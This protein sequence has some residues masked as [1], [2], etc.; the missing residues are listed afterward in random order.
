MKPKVS[1]RPATMDDCP[2]IAKLLS[3]SAR[4]LA[5]HDYPDAAIDAALGTGAWG[6]DTQLIED[7]TYYLVFI[8]S[9]LAACGG[10]SFRRTLFSADSEPTRNADWLD[11]MVDDARIRAFFVHPHF[12]RRGLGSLLL[13]HCEEAAQRAGFQSFAL[14]ATL[15][16]KRLYK[17][18]GYIA[19]DSFD[20]D[21]GAG[22]TMRGLL[23][24]KRPLRQAM[25]VSS[26]VSRTSALTTTLASMGL[27]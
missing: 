13:K 9:T 12:A 23:M 21:V 1:I 15:P 19:T 24:T 8:G 10:W 26:A 2:S 20:Y 18:H 11:P 16:G 3:E 5:R 4:V 14:A 7:E 6:L 27:D 22:L 17:V 25:P